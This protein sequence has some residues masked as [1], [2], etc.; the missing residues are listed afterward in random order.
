MIKLSVYM[1]HSTVNMPV[2]IRID[3]VINDVTVYCS[4]LWY[5]RYNDSIFALVSV[6]A[7]GWFT[8]AWAPCMPQGPLDNWQDARSS[9]SVPDLCNFSSEMTVFSLVHVSSSGRPS[10]SPVIYVS[11]AFTKNRWW[12]VHKHVA[13]LRPMIKVVGDIWIWV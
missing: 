1:Y 3:Y 9:E 13:T 12:T 10:Q 5:V 7:L 6:I 8:I 4:S 11:P 2:W